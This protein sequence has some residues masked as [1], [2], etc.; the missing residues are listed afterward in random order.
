V[1]QQLAD[2]GFSLLPPSRLRTL[3]D[4][5]WD[6]SAITGDARFVFVARAISPV[7]TLWTE[8][9]VTTALAAELDSIVKRLL[10]AILAEPDAPTACSL[11]RSLG[12]ELLRAFSNT[13]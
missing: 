10:P 9:P 4:W 11:A 6:W 1:L 5:C 12:D 2:V 8:D 13:R 3:V 7:D